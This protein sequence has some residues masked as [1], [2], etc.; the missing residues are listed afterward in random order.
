[1]LRSKENNYKKIGIFEKVYFQCKLIKQLIYRFH[2]IKHEFRF[3]KHKK[4][5]R[6]K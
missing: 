4:V 2:N 3:K 1:M 6:E 5:V